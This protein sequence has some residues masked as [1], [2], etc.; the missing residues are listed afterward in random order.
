MTETYA[1]WDIVRVPYPFTEGVGE[2]RRPALVINGRALAREHHFYWLVMITSAVGTEWDG[3]VPIKNLAA[4]GL[5][6]PS[7]VRTAKIVTVQEDRIMGRLGHLAAAETR[8]V[9]K[10]LAKWLK[11]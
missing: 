2:K 1:R 8:Q 9:E 10:A 3:D 7:V 11:E 4:A 6:V 5:P